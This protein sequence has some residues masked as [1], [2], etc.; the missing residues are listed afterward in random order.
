M[1]PSGP[2]AEASDL[3]KL[4]SAMKGE[5][6]PEDERWSLDSSDVNW[7][8]N[9][10]H[11]W[12]V[13]P[14]RPPAYMIINGAVF[15]FPLKKGRLALLWFRLRIWWATRRARKSGAVFIETR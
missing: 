1:R 6:V 4:A 12:V 13:I 2:M 3:K 10:P 9:A 15:P 5:G 8:S 7:S 11:S 14:V